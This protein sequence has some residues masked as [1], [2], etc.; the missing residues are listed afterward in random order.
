MQSVR[1]CMWCACMPV[2]MHVCVIKHL[3]L[4]KKSML[5]SKYGFEYHKNEF[6]VIAE[7]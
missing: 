2:Y 1:V 6:C 3:V 5:C 4:N 7:A